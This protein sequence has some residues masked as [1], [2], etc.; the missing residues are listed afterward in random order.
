MYQNNGV[1]DFADPARTPFGLV[2]R[3][4]KKKREGEGRR[5]HRKV[6]TIEAKVSQMLITPLYGV[7]VSEKIWHRLK[8]S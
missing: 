4:I 8:S 6:H 1:S 7:L 5:E 2:K 3:M